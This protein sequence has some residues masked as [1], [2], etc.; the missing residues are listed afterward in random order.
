L[1]G[2]PES[3][4]ASELST[5]SDPQTEAPR[6]L[7][8]APQNRAYPTRIDRLVVTGAKRF[9]QIARAVFAKSSLAAATAPSR[10]PLASK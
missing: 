6:W 8:A 10:E 4:F 5:T 3:V 9:P 1:K 2:L 7:P